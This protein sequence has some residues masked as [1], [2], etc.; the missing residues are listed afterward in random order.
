MKEPS[1]ASVKEKIQDYRRT[2]KNF[3]QSFPV[4]ILSDIKQL[5]TSNKN[6]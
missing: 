6:P 1:V 3:R 2:S 4:E 5:L